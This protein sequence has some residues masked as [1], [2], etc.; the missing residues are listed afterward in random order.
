[1][2]LKTSTC[3]ALA[4]LLAACWLV[5]PARAATPAGVTMPDFPLPKFALD[6]YGQADEANGMRLLR[7]LHKGGVHGLEV[8]EAADDDYVILS[9]SSLGLLAAWLEA[10]CKSLGTEVAQART[11]TYNGVVYADFLEVATS[12][13]ADRKSQSLLAI[14]LGVMI[15]K[16]IKPWGVLPGD[17]ARDAYVL[18]AT[19][20]GFV[21]Y[22]PPTRQSALLADYP[23]NTEVLKIRL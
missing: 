17:G 12:I 14:P 22:D 8:F 16:R 23:N 13:A 20:R 1:M 21:V 4:G 3:S 6:S 19:E 7:E 15:C 18:V 9:S 10:A 2:I 5:A 11:S